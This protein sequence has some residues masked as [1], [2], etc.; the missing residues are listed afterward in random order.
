MEKQNIFA[1]SF[2]TMTSQG[3]SIQ[4]P[5]TVHTNC[6]DNFN[7]IISCVQE[8]NAKCQQDAYNIFRFH[9]VKPSF[10]FSSP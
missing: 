1:L 10:F 2:A 8:L 5:F 6:A 7:Y 3:C 4:L 9:F